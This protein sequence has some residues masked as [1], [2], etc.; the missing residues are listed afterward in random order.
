[1]RQLH[2]VSNHATPYNDFLFRSLAASSIDLIVHF[3]K[4]ILVSHPW[5]SEMA[6]GFRSRFYQ[7]RFGLDWQLLRKASSDRESLFIIGGWIDPT[8]I[9][10]INLL[11]LRKRPFAIW[12]DTPD[13]RSRRSFLK[14][15]LRAVWVRRVFAHVTWAMATGCPGVEALAQMGCPQEKL[16]NFPFFIDLDWFSPLTVKTEPQEPNARIRLISSG[17]LLNSHKGYDLA[18]RALAAVRERRPALDLIYRIAGTG[19]DRSR[20]KALARDLGLS[21]Q[22]EFCGWLE[23]DELPA[24]YRSGDLFLHP[25]HFDPFPNAV[26]EAMACGLPVVGSDAAGSVLDRVDHEQNGLIHRAGNVQ[27]LVEK[28]LCAVKDWDGLRRMGVAAR[29]TA[30]KWPVRRG[31]ERVKQM[32]NQ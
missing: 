8:M 14:T 27:D 18:L 22:I 28:I 24:F 11:I 9:A 30:E 5:K 1:V 17:R 4:P 29:R 3:V 16:V 23:P 13:M 19:P 21:D 12:T 6:T 32:L 7:T 26:L 15:G 10:L 25:S 2:W 20:L 31:I